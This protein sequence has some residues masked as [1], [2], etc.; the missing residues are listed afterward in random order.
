MR[1][2]GELGLSPLLAELWEV[3]P[4]RLEGRRQDLSSVEWGWLEALWSGGRGGGLG[5][6]AAYLSDWEPLAIFDDFVDSPTLSV[7]PDW[8]TVNTIPVCGK[9]PECWPLPRI[10]FWFYLQT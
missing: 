8:T 7:G 9:E 10:T 6:T 3:R 5:T 1:A 4:G 2:P